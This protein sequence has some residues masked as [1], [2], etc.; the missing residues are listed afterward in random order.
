MTAAPTA[1]ISLHLSR[2]AG[3]EAAVAAGLAA[4][5]DH[6]LDHGGVPHNEH[7]KKN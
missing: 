3:A 7:E 6:S 2:Q 4:V 1:L 5:V